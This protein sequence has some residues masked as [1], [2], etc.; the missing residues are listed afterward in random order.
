MTRRIINVLLAFFAFV[1]VF[2]YIFLPILLHQQ[3]VQKKLSGWISE[4]TK[5]TVKFDSLSLA[6]F[7]SLAFKIKNFSYTSQDADEPF[8]LRGEMLKARLNIFSIL[9]R[10]PQLKDLTIKNASLEGK[11]HFF[12]NEAV[13]FSLTGFSVE[14]RGIRKQSLGSFKARGSF[15]SNKNNFEVK[16][17]LKIGDLGRFRIED[18]LCDLTLTLNRV[19][20]EPILMH[21]LK[22][23]PLRVIGGD[24]TGT[25]KVIKKTAGRKGEWAAELK[26]K[27][28]VFAD[29]SNPTLSFPKSSQEWTSRGSWETETGKLSIFSSR[30]LADGL[31]G[32]LLGDFVINQKGIEKFD[33]HISFKRYDFKKALI[34]FPFLGLWFRTGADLTGE[35]EIRFHS[36]GDFDSFNAQGELVLDQAAISSDYFVK[37][38][39]KPLNL[40]GNFTLKHRNEWSGDFDL[41]FQEFKAKGALLGFNT[42]NQDLRF[43]L[44]TN[45]FR[46]A[47]FLEA[48]ASQGERSVWDGDIKV[49]L[50]YKGKLADPDQ[51]EIRGV[52]NLDQVSY[53]LQG[54]PF[55][56][57]PL[58][59]TIKIANQEAYAEES[60]FY[61]GDE[62]APLE[63]EWLG[64]ENPRIYWRSTADKI[65][66]KTL[67]V[68]Q[69][70][71][72]AEGAKK[73]TLDDL[74]KSLFADATSE[75]LSENLKKPGTLPVW[76]ERLKAMGE[77]Q[78]NEV[79]LGQAPFRQVK[80]AM[81]MEAGRWDLVL[82]G[83]GAGGELWFEAD[84]D[85]TYAALPQVRLQG[86][87]LE[88]GEIIPEA[89]KGTVFFKFYNLR[90]PMDNVLWRGSALVERGA[91]QSFSLLGEGARAYKNL[92]AVQGT[93]FLNVGIWVEADENR[94]VLSEV[95]LTSKPLVVQ[96]VSAVGASGELD[97][98]GRLIFSSD[99]SRKWNRKVSADEKLVSDFE[100]KETLAAPQ[101]SV[102]G[103]SSFQAVPRLFDREISDRLDSLK[104][105]TREEARSIR[106]PEKE[107]FL[108]APAAERPAPEKKAGFFEIFFGKRR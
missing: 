33:T 88:L 103:K 7:P 49:L 65:D 82:S 54:I 25:V 9:A 12:S 99:V 107:K 43:N 63:L 68:P 101:V 58:V 81:T 11:T 13:P 92:E 74:K 44:L 19:P 37:P 85:L 71:V 29:P 47:T 39:G 16:G 106:L 57:P 75:K 27:D 30:L 102:S 28:I 97:M 55:R 52:V 77:I 45:K 108:S 15:F 89:G 84:E 76:L 50:N 1:V 40:K 67:A 18:L 8:A 4:E 59:A 17:S 6:F 56:T 93:E 69:K 61:F 51:A 96:A 72:S 24:M 36:K 34:H 64:W 48:T 41:V 80:G 10:N 83:R 70:G 5:G 78:M 35:G 95:I 21:R 3:G 100:L 38:K 46:L 105:L 23:L 87:R 2:Q 60:F 22:L 91:F 90:K 32:E 14:A 98:K 62:K 42:A 66:L 53:R 73:I 86:K 26:F 104:F 79:K 20:L 31:D 94:A